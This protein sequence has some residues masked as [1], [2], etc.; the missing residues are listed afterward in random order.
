MDFYAFLEESDEEPE[1]KKPSVP[2]KVSQTF[3]GCIGTSSKTRTK[4]EQVHYQ[5]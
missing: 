2:K 4:N 5:T 1:V 3:F